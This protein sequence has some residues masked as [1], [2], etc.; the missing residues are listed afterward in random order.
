MRLMAR[1]SAALAMTLV[2]Y[3]IALGHLGSPAEATNIRDPAR[4]E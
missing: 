1:L 3:S 2:A 4:G